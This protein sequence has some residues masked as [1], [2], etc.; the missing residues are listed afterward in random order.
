MKF[1]DNTKWGSTVNISEDRNIIHR[2]LEKTETWAGN[3]MRLNS[4]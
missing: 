4:I 3:E 1:A 2:N